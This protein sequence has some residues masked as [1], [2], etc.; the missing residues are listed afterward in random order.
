MILGTTILV[1]ATINHSVMEYHT[2]LLHPLK[3]RF[4]WVDCAWSHNRMAKINFVKAAECDFNYEHLYNQWIS[5]L[6][7][8]KLL[9]DRSTEINANTQRVTKDLMNAWT[10]CEDAKNWHPQGRYRIE[11]NKRKHFF[12]V[13]KIDGHLTPEIPSNDATKQIVIEDAIILSQV[14]KR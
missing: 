12:F 9:N 7:L 8:T 1:I 4:H 3:H 6:T 13:Q 14:Q 10:G 5:S 2:S 11:F